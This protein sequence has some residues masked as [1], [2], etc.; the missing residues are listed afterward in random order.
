M[1]RLEARLSSIENPLDKLIASHSE[2]MKSAEESFP[3][4]ER[5]PIEYDNEIYNIQSLIL[6][7]EPVEATAGKYVQDLIKPPLPPSRKVTA[8]QEERSLVLS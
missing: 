5:I 6:A 7:S 3:E 1:N 2:L 4:V 8:R